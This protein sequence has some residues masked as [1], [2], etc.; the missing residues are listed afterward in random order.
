MVVKTLPYSWLGESSSFGLNVAVRPA[1]VTVP[2]IALDLYLPELGVVLCS[3]VNVFVFTV[4]GSI[5]LL[6]ITLISSFLDTSCSLFATD[7][8]IIFGRFMSINAVT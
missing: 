6:N 7:K 4:K 1:Y 3:T 5:S 8:E 2:S